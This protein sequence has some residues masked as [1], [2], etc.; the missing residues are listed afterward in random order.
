M[1]L[2][3]LAANGATHEV[4]NEI[5]KTLESS[6]KEEILPVAFTL[7]SLAFGRDN[8]ADQ[9]WLERSYKMH[10]ILKDTPIYQVMTREAHEE[11]LQQGLQQGLQ[12]A[13]LSI[14][15]ERF[16]KLVRLAK[17]QI[18]VIEEPEV[19]QLLVVKVSVAKNAE[20]AKQYLL[21][22]DEDEED[23]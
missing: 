11:G 12:R 3:I 7:I 18:A 9:E 23:D 5:F 20:E 1:P 16:P 17:K 4:A 2:M 15:A 10:D 14:I 6:G 19:L 22:V 13:L 21:E 8:T